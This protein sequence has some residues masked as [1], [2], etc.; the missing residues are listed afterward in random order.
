MSM[1]PSQIEI[2]TSGQFTN[3]RRGVRQ[4]CENFENK[5]PDAIARVWKDG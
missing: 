3:P 1:S 2:D 5:I 4:L